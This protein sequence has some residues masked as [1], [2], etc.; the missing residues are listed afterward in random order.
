MEFGN[1]FTDFLYKNT[2]T[3]IIG[4]SVEYEYYTGVEVGNPSGLTSNIKREI[5]IDGDGNTQFVIN[6]QWSVENMIIEIFTTKD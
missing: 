2:W 5:Y 1:H 4:N 6:Y 3:S